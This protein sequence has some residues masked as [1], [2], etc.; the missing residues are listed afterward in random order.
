LNEEIEE[1]EDRI[2]DMLEDV[3]EARY[4]LS[5]PGVDLVTAAAVISECQPPTLFVLSLSFLFR[6]SL[7]HQ[8]LY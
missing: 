1:I 8:V 3:D 4:L 7:I 5:I 2:R 6:L